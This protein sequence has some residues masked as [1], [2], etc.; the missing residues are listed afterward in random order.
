MKILAADLGGTSIRLGLV[1]DT[2]VLADASVASRAG[3]GLAARLPAMDATFAALCDRAGVERVSIDAVGLALP[4]LVNVRTNRIES[5]D[6]KF[7]DAAAVDLDAWARESWSSPVV[8]EGDANAALAGEWLCGAARAF[9]NVCLMALGTGVGTAAIVDGRLLRG[10]S[11][12]AGILVGHTTIDVDGVT[13]G[14]GNVGC[15]ETIGS[16]WALTTLARRH[17]AYAESALRDIDNIDYETVFRVAATGDQV[18]IDLQGRSLR[19]WGAAAVTLIH[20]YNPQ[21]IVLTGGVMRSG[22]IVLNTL[23]RYVEQHT[24]QGQIKAELVPAQLGTAAALLGM[25]YLAAR[26]LHTQ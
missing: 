23:R 11:G 22:D 1:D 16:T 20:A 8:L 10:A 15:V 18:A 4:S 6:D 7:P 2:R 5:T 24:W 9:D 3:D 26:R 19:A 13:C 12:Y 17:P 25:G 14:C 21:C